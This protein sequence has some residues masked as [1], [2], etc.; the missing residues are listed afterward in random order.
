M[1]RVKEAIMTIEDMFNEEFEKFEKM[2][3]DSLEDFRKN[4][5]MNE[6]VVS[7]IQMATCEGKLQAY[8]RVAKELLGDESLEEKYD[9]VVEKYVNDAMEIVGITADEMDDEDGEEDE[10]ED[11]SDFD[12]KFNK[13]FEEYMSRLRS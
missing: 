3:A 11:E 2:I 10:D 4:G 7:E 9:A 5:S 13:A 6:D 8:E 1:G 12:E